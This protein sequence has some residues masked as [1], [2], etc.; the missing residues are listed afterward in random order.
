MRKTIFL[1]GL[2]FLLLMPFSAAA[3]LVPC[4][5]RTGVDCQLCHLFVL[6]DNILDLVMFRI[7]PVLASLMLMIGG[8]WYFF[9]GVSPEQKNKAQGIITSSIIGIVVILTAWIVVNTILVHSGIV[10][11]SIAPWHQIRCPIN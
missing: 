5:P 9:A 6:L 7:V 3:R 4:G 11:G 8:I 1:I 10:D 2:L